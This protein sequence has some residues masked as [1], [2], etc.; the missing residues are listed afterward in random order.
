MHLDSNNLFREAGL[1]EEL[2]FEKP[3]RL[4]SSLEIQVSED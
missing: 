2:T 4:L 1:H 3:H